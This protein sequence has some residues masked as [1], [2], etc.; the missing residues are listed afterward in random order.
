MRLASGM[1]RKLPL[2]LALGA[3]GCRL[4]ERD[5]DRAA[6]GATE[7]ESAP[8]STTTAP[9]L[10]PREL[11]AAPDVATIAERVTPA[12]VNITATQERGGGPS[13]SLGPFG[14]GPF[15]TDPNG[16]RVLQRE[17]LGSGFIV[18][19]EGRIV[20]NAHVLEG[21]TSVTVRLWDGRELDAV[22]IGRDP[23][24]DLAVLELEDSPP[25]LPVAALGSSEA[26][27]VG[28]YVVA[29]GN[30]FGLGNTVTL[31]IVSA[32]GR[33]IGAGPY[34]DFIQTDASI[35]PGNSG[36]PLFDMRGRVVGINAAI[37]ATGQGIGF[38]IPVDSLK[39]VLE[40]LVATGH[41]E[42]ARLGVEIGEPNVELGERLGVG[43]QGA[44]VAGVERGGPAAEAGVRRGEVI[45][46]VDGEPVVRAQELP[47]M[48]ASRR[49]GDRVT[50]TVVG[51]GGRRDVVATLE[52]LEP[53]APRRMR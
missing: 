27:R 48:I 6:P 30:P 28:E 5:G 51:P 15:G 24:L 21:A 40:Q 50:L 41:V 9:P 20:T 19:R 8:L 43:R 22:V 2:A 16:D 13:F 3:A 17:A 7:L 32:K 34:D 26:V 14:L 47:R 31:G 38:A 18:D 11:P 25:D 46:A 29:V 45:V 49:A 39:T 36:G 1:A 42:R 10:P 37:A 4:F 12:V 35:N 33:A 44:L 23:P 52:R 53:K